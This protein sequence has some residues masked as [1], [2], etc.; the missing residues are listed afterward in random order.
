MFTESHL[1]STPHQIRWTTNHTVYRV[2]VCLFLG[3]SRS[4]RLSSKLPRRT[5][6]V[7]PYRTN[8]KTGKRNMSQDVEVSP[9]SN[10]P[11]CFAGV[12]FSP[13]PIKMGKLDVL[14]YTSLI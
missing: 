12:I 1:V 13:V 4:G 3:V 7:G 6:C 14:R 10:T 5:T 11:L 2:P 8:V 9:L